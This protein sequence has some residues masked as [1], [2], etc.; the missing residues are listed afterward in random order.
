MVLKEVKSIVP[1]VP[2]VGG[3]TRRGSCS[4]DQCIGVVIGSVGV[5]SGVCVFY[6]YA[7]PGG[8]GF[9]GG[10]MDGRRMTIDG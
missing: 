6:R 1:S 10:W 8:L 9:S 7:S 5:V 4:V 2:V 3:G